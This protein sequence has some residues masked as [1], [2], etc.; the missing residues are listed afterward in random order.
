VED[1]YQLV[2]EPVQLNLVDEDSKR[3]TVLYG[4]IA[5]GWI[6]GD[7]FMFG[8]IFDAVATG[9]MPH[10]TINDLIRGAR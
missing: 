6:E 5:I 7:T 3:L 9:S 1:T 4:P 10:Y 8:R 2:S